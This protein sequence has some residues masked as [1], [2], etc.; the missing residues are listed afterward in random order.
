MD[1]END[2]LVVQGSAHANRYSAIKHILFYRACVPHIERILLI[3][4]GRKIQ[5]DDSRRVGHRSDTLTIIPIFPRAGI[6]AT[7]GIFTP[8]RPSINY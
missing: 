8:Q 5:R 4:Y 6:R 1:S 7:G 2:V 3:R